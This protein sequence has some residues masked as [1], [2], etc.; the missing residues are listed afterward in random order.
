MRISIDI[1]QWKVEQQSS[2]NLDQTGNTFVIL[3][4]EKTMEIFSRTEARG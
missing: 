3:Q 1:Y 2:V 4:N